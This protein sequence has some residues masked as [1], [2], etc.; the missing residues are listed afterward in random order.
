MT[1]REA[2]FVV[3]FDMDGVL[4]DHTANKVAIA[5]EMGLTVLPEATHSEEIRSIFKDIEDYRRFQGL[6]YYDHPIALTV[7]LMPDVTVVLDR[8]VVDGTPFVLVSRRRDSEAAIRILKTQGL[9]G[10]YFSD[11][12]AAFVPSVAEKVARAQ[13]FGVTRYIDDERK[14]IRAMEGIIAEPVLFD[15]HDRFGD[16]PHTRVRSWMEFLHLAS[17]VLR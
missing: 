13:S 7:P 4:L 1:I 3:G 10:K 8:L 9:W 14:V 17:P 5:R 6:L 11:K 2:N 12:N 15:Q 16:T